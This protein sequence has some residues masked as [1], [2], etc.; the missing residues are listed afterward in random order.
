MSASQYADTVRPTLEEVKRLGL[1]A[2]M[3]LPSRVYGTDTSWM[4]TLYQRIPNLNTTS[5]PSPT[6]PIG[7]ATTRPRS[8]PPARSGGST[9]C[10]GG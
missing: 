9:R 1:P 10:A 7:M 3:I 4:D 8:A 2:K 6:I 5:T